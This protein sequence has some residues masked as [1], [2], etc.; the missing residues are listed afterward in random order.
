MPE[1]DR[2]RAFV[3]GPWKGRGGAERLISGRDVKTAN[4]SEDSEEEGGF[5]YGERGEVWV[6]NSGSFVTWG[7]TE[8]E[9]RAF[10][11]HVIRRKVANVERDSL[12]LKDYEVEEMD[13]VVDPTA[14]VVPPPIRP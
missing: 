11:R 7:L 10:L 3:I 5:G 6:F 14:S 2:E 12:P 13:F 9:G 1:G 8:E 4:E